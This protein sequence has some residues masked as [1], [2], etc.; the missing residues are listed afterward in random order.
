MQILLLVNSE[1]GFGCSPFVCLDV[2][3]LSAGTSFSMNSS[4]LRQ[5]SCV[6]RFI[7]SHDLPA[8]LFGDCQPKVFQQLVGGFGRAS[9]ALHYPAQL[10]F[11]DAGILAD[12]VSGLTAAPDVFS[13]SLNN[14][15]NNH[16]S[17]SLPVQYKLL[18]GS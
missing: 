16:I 4:I 11:A 14:H 2:Y 8:F 15:A 6:C 13:D 10:V 9:P 18:L 1:I 3:V 7:D 12:A 5:S 17:K